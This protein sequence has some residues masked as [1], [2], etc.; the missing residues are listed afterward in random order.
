MMQSFELPV[1]PALSIKVRE[2]SSETVSA[3]QRDVELRIVQPLLTIYF[4]RAFHVRPQ[5]FSKR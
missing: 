5:E 3:T 2:A 4:E 1:N